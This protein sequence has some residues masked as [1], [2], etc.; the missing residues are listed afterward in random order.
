MTYQHNVSTV[1]ISSFKS[2]NNG[3]GRYP[4]FNV[5]PRVPG[6]TVP[7]FTWLPKLNLNL[8]HE[9]VNYSLAAEVPGESS[10]GLLG[11]QAAY[12][13]LYLIIVIAEA[14]EPAR[15]GLIH[16]KVYSAPLQ[17]GREYLRASPIP[18]SLVN[19]PNRFKRY[20]FSILQER[21]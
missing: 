16:T 12:S 2:E 17:L 18:Y 1:L 8:S 20:Q 11:L 9:V 14:A 10:V 5:P 19:S 6:R 13:T 7:C 15:P 3:H 21:A 4:G